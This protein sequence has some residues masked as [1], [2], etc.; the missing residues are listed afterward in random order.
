MTVEYW[1]N[2]ERQRK[3]DRLT[4]TCPITI[5]F[6]TSPTY[7]ESGL[8]CNSRTSNC[9]SRGEINVKKSSNK[10]RNALTDLN[11]VV[12]LTKKNTDSIV[13][14]FA[15][16]LTLQNGDNMKM[17]NEHNCS[18]PCNLLCDF[19]PRITDWKPPRGHTVA[20]Q[21]STIPGYCKLK[22]PSF[23]HACHDTLFIFHRE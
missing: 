10:P 17:Y 1:Q 13:L 18:T 23:S 19:A 15:W 14:Y 4:E 12:S 20:S 8:R 22:L 2:N 9:F 7:N 6:I 3:T 11:T 5:L 16:S 21:S